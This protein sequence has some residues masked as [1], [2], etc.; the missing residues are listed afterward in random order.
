MATLG[1]QIDVLE[2]GLVKGPYDQLSRAFK[3]M[4]KTL[5]AAI[6]KT[7]HEIGA[8]ARKTAAGSTSPAQIAAALRSERTRIARLREQLIESQAAERRAL[9]VRSSCSALSQ[10]CNARLQYLQE[11]H[12]LP[13]DEPAG[14]NWR[15]QRLDRLVIDALLREGM[16][17]TAAE[18][19]RMTNL[20]DLVDSHVFDRAHEIELALNNHD[21]GPAL[22]WCAE[23]AER[24]AKLNSSLEIRL[25]IQQFVEF[26]R[27]GRKLDAIAFARL[28]FPKQ[29]SKHFDLIRSASLLLALPFPSPYP[30]YQAMYEDSA[31]TELVSLFRR[32]N[33]VLHGL[34]LQSSLSTA[35][36]IGASV[37]KTRSCG[38]AD[39]CNRN[40]PTCNSDLYTLAEDLQ[41]AHHDNS[42]LVCRIT[43]DL[44]NEN[45]P[46]M[47][48]P[49]GCVYGE[50]GL[51]EIA[52]QNDGIV[53]CPRTG[54]RF[55]VKSLKKVF[56]M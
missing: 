9:E 44:M 51:N 10:L 34:S 2:Y 47:M 33:L 11:G 29:G 35:L 31:W 4:H 45:N 6:A 26:V 49:N 38:S 5:E 7:H 48:L 23:H 15:N 40:C 46:P 20:A 24:L 30:Q 16:Y 36:Q 19:T 13:T 28:Y 52:S 22:A 56:V 41:Y 18:L 54:D 50:K 42:Q 17:Q 55:P 27:A 14:E 12:T 43:G 8:L 39:D 25:R 21:C 37:F 53:V 32:N 1:S 3:S